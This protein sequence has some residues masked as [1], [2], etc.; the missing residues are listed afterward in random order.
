MFYFVLSLLHLI[1]VRIFLI[2]VAF[3]S[4]YVGFNPPFPEYTI[5]HGRSEKPWLKR[6]I[7]RNSPFCKNAKTTF[8]V[9]LTNWKIL[10]IRFSH[11]YCLT[12]NVFYIHRQR[13][14]KESS[15]E[16]EEGEE[17]EVDDEDGEEEKENVGN[18]KVER[19]KKRTATPSPPKTAKKQVGKARRRVVARSVGP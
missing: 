12:F 4:N 11:D 3:G 14:R 18:K 7:G 6:R 10:F 19:A 9:S 1:Y 17:E 2:C 15:D 5:D 8:S 13:A 16:E